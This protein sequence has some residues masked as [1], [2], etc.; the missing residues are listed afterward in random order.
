M[1]KKHLPHAGTRPRPRR[2]LPKFR[3]WAASASVTAK[4]RRVKDSPEWGLLAAGLALDQQNHTSDLDALE[5]AAIIPHL[6]SADVAIVTF[7]PPDVVTE[8]NI[9]LSSLSEEAHYVLDIIFNGPAEV[10]DVIMSPELGKISPRSISKHLKEEGWPAETVANTME[11]LTA[12]V[13]EM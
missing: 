11:E 8:K 7:P 6:A 12:Y 2:W 5:G 3:E 13:G 1:K 10:W 9:R 4:P